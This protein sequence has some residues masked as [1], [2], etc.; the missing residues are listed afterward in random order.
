MSR[1]K[2]LSLRE[3]RRL[4][5]LGQFAKENPIEADKDQF[6]A[7]VDAMASGKPPKERRTSDEDVCED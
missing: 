7:L 1:G 3:A 4:G 5:K 2:H 6:D